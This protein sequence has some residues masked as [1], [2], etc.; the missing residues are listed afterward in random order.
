[1]I[2]IGLALIGFYAI[3]K[4]MAKARAEKQM[5]GANASMSDDYIKRR[6]HIPLWIVI[7][8]YLITTLAYILVS[9]VLIKWHPGVMVVLLFYGFLY[10][11]LISYVT[12]RLEGMVG[13][14][15][16]IPLIKEAG[17]ILSGFKG[18]E[19]WFIPV[20]LGNYGLHTVFYRQSELVGSRFRAIW[21]S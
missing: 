6:G 10:T 15:V 17:F 2:A 18:I 4:G 8:V 14:A 11:P 20:P 5:L 9:G 19:I 12:A 21:K 16:D 13:Q 3:W 1:G 7:G